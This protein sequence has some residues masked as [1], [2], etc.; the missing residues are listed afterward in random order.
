MGESFGVTPLNKL[1]VYEGPE[2]KNQPVCS[3]LELHKFVRQFYYLNFWGAGVPVVS[4][5]K[6]DNWKSGSLLCKVDIS[7]AFRQLKMDPGDIHL[8]G[9]KLDSYYIDQSVPFG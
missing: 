6:I 7:Q 5:L 1:R 4:I 2:T 8:L 9:L 3:P